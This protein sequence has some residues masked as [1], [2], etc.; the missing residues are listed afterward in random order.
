MLSFGVDK[1]SVRAAS[2]AP[3]RSLSSGTPLGASCGKASLVYGQG[4][5]PQEKLM[6]GLGRGAYVRN[7]TEGIRLKALGGRDE[8]TRTKLKGFKLEGLG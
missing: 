6:F 5:N 1:T 4:V 3:A 2:D 7:S 8:D